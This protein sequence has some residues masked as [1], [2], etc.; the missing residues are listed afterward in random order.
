MKAA[1]LLRMVDIIA[2][3]RPYEIKEIGIRPG[4]KV[5]ETMRTG[6]DWCMRSDTWEQ[7][8]DLELKEL[9]GVQ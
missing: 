3:G 4:E 9:I 1:S 7:Y 5:H 6:H 2:N 8:T